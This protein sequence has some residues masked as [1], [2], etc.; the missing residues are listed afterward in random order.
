[1]LDRDQ[2]ENDNQQLVLGENS[3]CRYRGDLEP[4]RALHQRKK[5]LRWSQSDK[6]DLER[7]VGVV[8]A[9]AWLLVVIV[10]V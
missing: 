5:D 7:V 3:N 6:T 2:K 10:D 8:D 4:K 9:V 1:M